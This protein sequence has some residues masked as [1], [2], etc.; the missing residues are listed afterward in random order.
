MPGAAANTLPIPPTASK[1]TNNR[2][3]NID[4]L[5]DFS[6]L[7]IFSS[8]MRPNSAGKMAICS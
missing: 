6:N 5:Y 1:P 8:F 3:I 4:D 7:I 2:A